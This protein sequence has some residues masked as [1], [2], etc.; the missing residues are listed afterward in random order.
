[1]TSIERAGEPR[2]CHAD[3]ERYQEHLDELVRAGYITS[4]DERNVLAGEIG[5][6]QT[7]QVLR[8]VLALRGLPDLADTADEGRIDWGVPRNFVPAGTLT[9]T[10]SLLT[11]VV[12]AT[13]LAHYHDTLSNVLCAW[14]LVLG[15]VGTVVSV[16]ALVAGFVCW[17]DQQ[18]DRRRERVARDRQRRAL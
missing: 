3:R 16:I 4:T 6:A 15:I 14:F 13:A 5:Q 18:P 9:L 11:A 7:R 17:D 12:P 8:R 2:A 1:M 10:V